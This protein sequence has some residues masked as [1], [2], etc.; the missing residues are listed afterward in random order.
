MNTAVREREFL[1]E[2]EEMAERGKRLLEKIKLSAP[3]Q[4]LEY[5]EQGMLYIEAALEALTT[6]E[7]VLEAWAERFMKEALAPEE[8]TS[9]RRDISSIIVLSPATS[10]K[11]LSKGRVLLLS[12]LA[13]RSI[14]SISELAELAKK[15][16]EVVSRDLK[17]LRNFGFVD[18]KREGRRKRPIV[19]KN[20]IFLQL[21][22]KRQRGR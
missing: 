15:P 20:Y 22:S 18:L 4:A 11:V 5:F 14:S 13:Q 12:L 3:S 9:L 7:G 19:M 16:L 2:L 21:P 1:D 6:P 8:K 10:K 17:V